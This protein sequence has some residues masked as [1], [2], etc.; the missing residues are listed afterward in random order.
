MIVGR[1]GGACDCVRVG[2]V[3]NVGETEEEE[4]GDVEVRGGGSLVVVDFASAGDDVTVYI[5]RC[6]GV[7]VLAFC[8][9][10]TGGEEYTTKC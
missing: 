6:E 8:G 9:C 1:E 2:R 3:V 4:T 5:W 10:S 7:R